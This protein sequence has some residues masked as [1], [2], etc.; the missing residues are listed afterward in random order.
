MT[1][2]FYEFVAK[3]FNLMSM[4]R[5]FPVGIPSMMSGDLPIQF[6]GREPAFFDIILRLL[7]RDDSAWG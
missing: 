4:L 2:D 1:T 6:P 3:H 5:S 7:C